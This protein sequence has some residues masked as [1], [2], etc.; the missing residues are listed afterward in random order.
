MI[1]S[2]D[3]YPLARRLHTLIP[4]QLRRWTGEVGNPLKRDRLTDNLPMELTQVP[5]V[6]FAEDDHEGRDSG[7]HDQPSPGGLR[8][9][10]G[11][12]LREFRR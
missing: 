1:T 4:A 10:V 12:P 11:L 9:D 6:P 7:R 3:L 5:D 8:H 2:A